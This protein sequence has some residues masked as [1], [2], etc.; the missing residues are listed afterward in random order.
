MVTTLGVADGRLLFFGRPKKWYLAFDQIAVLDFDNTFAQARN[1]SRDPHLLND[2]Q[3]LAEQG[4]LSSVDM[5]SVPVLERFRSLPL[6]RDPQWLQFVKLVNAVN[7]GFDRE[8][9]RR[10][11]ESGSDEEKH[12]AK[13]NWLI[14]LHAAASLTAQFYAPFLAQSG[15]QTVPII[16]DVLPVPQLEDSR[17]AVMRVVVDS[18]PEA[19]D[20]T[21]WEDL[22]EFKNDPLT[23]LQYRELLRWVQSLKEAKRTDQEL[24]D[25]I[26]YLLAAFD[27]HVRRARLKHTR[28]A[29]EWL[30]TIPL[31]MLED[32][33]NRRIVQAAQ[34]PFAGGRV[35]IELE[36]AERSAPGRDVAFVAKARERFAKR[37]MAR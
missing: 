5:S 19:D 31:A 20:T 15:V 28:G 10:V 6:A 33:I 26:D 18:L 30:I 36:Q 22:T 27:D 9:F 32:I 34:R 3:W 7:S 29:I 1:L 8:S 12:E 13:A 11:L 37:D 25:E 14:W 16:G 4:V 24:Q 17:V 35:R 23:R 2:F 21:P